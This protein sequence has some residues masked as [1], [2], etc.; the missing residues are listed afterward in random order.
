MK[1]L[2]LILP[3]VSLFSILYELGREHVPE[4]FWGGGRELLNGIKTVEHL[5]D[6]LLGSQRPPCVSLGRA[7]PSMCSANI[8]GMI[9]IDVLQTNL[10]LYCA[11][12]FFQ[13]RGKK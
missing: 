5:I 11:S 4:G 12:F 8:G 2:I 13:K 9:L 3:Q 7:G 1:V 10:S 6:V